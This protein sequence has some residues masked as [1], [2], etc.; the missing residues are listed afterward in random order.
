LVRWKP[1]VAV[2]YPDRVVP[3]DEK[4]AKE[5]EQRTLGNLYSDPP[6]WLKN[7]HRALDDAVAIAYDWPTDLSD[8][9]V[10][11]RLLALN[12]ERS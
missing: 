4:S 9:E 6:T 12:L 2:G 11:S 5:L 1:E 7:A 3:V 10:L 8:E